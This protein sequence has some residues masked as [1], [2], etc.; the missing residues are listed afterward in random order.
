MDYNEYL[1]SCLLKLYDKNFEQMEYDLQFDRVAHR[2]LGF[3]QSIFNDSQKGEYDCMIDYLEDKYNTKAG[4]YFSV[5]GY[6]LDDR[7]PFLGLICKEYD[8]MDEYEDE[9]VFF[10]GMGEKDLI[11]AIKFGEETIQDFVITS[12]EEVNF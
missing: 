4:K 8:D 3:Q 9:D 1:F 5:D 7:E 12:Y 6:W 10:Y 11:D 2:Y